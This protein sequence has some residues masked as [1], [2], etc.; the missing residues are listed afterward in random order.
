MST[1]AAAPCGD[2]RH[3]QYASTVLPALLTVPQVAARLGIHPNNVYEMIR[4]GQMPAVR[5]S[6]RKTRVRADV[7]DAYE[8]DL[9][10]RTAR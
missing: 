8:L 5:F 1:T 10:N 2:P 4:R 9:M 7:L 6:A 3:K